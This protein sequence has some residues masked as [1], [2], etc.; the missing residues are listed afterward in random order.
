MSML[1]KHALG[2]AASSV[3][4]GTAGA[5]CASLAAHSRTTHTNSADL[6]PL[7]PEVVGQNASHIIADR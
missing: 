7:S 6:I 2:N 1:S 3:S 4:T 5:V